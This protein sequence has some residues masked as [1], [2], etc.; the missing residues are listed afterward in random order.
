MT[1]L[2]MTYPARFPVHGPGAVVRVELHYGSVDVV[3]GPREDIAVTVTPSN[4]GRSGDSSA[5]AS[6]RIEQLGD[7]VVVKGPTRAGRFGLGIFV[8]KADSVDVLVEVPEHSDVNVEV[9]YGTLRLTGPLGAVR[10][11]LP[12]GDTS[13]EAADRLDLKGGHGD[14]QI[15]RVIG[16]ATVAF[17]SGTARIGHVGGGLQLKGTH[18][19]SSVRSL[20]GPSRL[21]T[22]SGS[23]EIGSSTA[24]AAV[25]SAYGS[26]RVHDAV[27]GAIQVDASYG[28]IEIAVRPGTAVWLD[29]NSEHGTV[30]TDLASD[31]GPV[32]D[33]HSLE[34]RL[35][36]GYGAISLRRSMPSP[37]IDAGSPPPSPDSRT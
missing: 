26:V 33:E 24:T 21:E 4:P 17:S 8:G 16:D 18:G 9:K 29:A 35:R 22:S 30:R 15:G 19:D 3:A 25:R 20:A 6:V 7:V 10:V 2:P 28:D 27:H 13:L 5:A 11:T 14:C 37:D 12:Y 34:L 1:E 32:E 23:I 36:T 31:S